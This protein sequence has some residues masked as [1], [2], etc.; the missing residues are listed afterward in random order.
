M[1]IKINA[2]SFS[3]FSIWPITSNSTEQKGHA[4]HIGF[5]GSLI[6]ESFLILLQSSQKCAKSLFWAY[7]NK[8]KMFRIVF[9]TFHGRL[10]PTWKKNLRLTHLYVIIQ[11]LCSLLL[12][13]IQNKLDK[14]SRSWFFCRVSGIY[15]SVPERRFWRHAWISSQ[16]TFNFFP[17]FLPLPLKR[18]QIKKISTLYTTNW[19]ILFWLSYTIFLIWPLFKG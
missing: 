12:G 2:A 18:G 7:P 16:F 5:K 9:G 4:A 15:I 1:V 3:K 17:R 14:F 10:E 19:R 13:W 11:V 8:K 6:S